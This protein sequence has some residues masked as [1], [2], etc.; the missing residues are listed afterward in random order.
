MLCFVS[1]S[2]EY[3][4]MFLIGLVVECWKKSGKICIKFVMLMMMSVIMISRLMFFFSV[5][6]E[7]NLLDW[8]F[9]FFFLLS[10]DYWGLGWLRNWCIDGF[11][12]LDGFEYIECY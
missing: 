10:C 12:V 8:L 7:K 6:C 11:V 9:M 4:V 1:C 2:G 3:G 5:L